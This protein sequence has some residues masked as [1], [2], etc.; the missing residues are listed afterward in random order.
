MCKYLAILLASSIFLSSSAE[1]AEVCQADLSWT[2][3]TLND[4]GSPLTDLTSYEI[5]NGC[6]Q[7]GVYDTVKIV[8]APA[9][10]DTVLGLPCAGTCYFAAKATNSVGT[11]SVFSN[12]AEK[13]MGLEP[14]PPDSESIAVSWQESASQPLVISNTQPDSYE[15]GMLAVGELV[16]IDR[17]YVF[18]VIPSALVGL[19]YLQTAN[20]DKR[21]TDSNSISF[22]IN[23]PA[24]VFVAF[25]HRISVPVWLSSWSAT[26]LIVNTSDSWFN[27]FSK[28]FAAGSVILG[29]NNGS[30]ESMYSVMIKEIQWL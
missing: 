3:P 16:Y 25:D 20:N 13:L 21:G 1:G 29:G 11:S 18:T 7:S 28:D 23:K 9:V 8:L 10:S 14:V 4:D 17:S 27:V 19:D 2:E 6:D 12:E 5:W 26:G 15:W 22:D 30:G 24:T